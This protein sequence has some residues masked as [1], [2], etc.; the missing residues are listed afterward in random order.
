MIAPKIS[1]TKNAILPK[2][3]EYPL[4]KFNLF[5]QHNSVDKKDKDPAYRT[6]ISWGAYLLTEKEQGG[7]QN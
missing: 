7:N 2:N 5:K 1:M 3:K 4:N 6:L